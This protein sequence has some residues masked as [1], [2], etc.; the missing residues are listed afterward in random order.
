MAAPASTS[1]RG[2]R[3]NRPPAPRRAGGGPGL[4]VGDPA[5][6]ATDAGPVIDEPARQALERH[7][8]RMAR[9]G[10]LLYGCPLPAGAEHGAFF[11]PRA[12]E[13]HSAGRLEREVFGPI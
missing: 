2:T 12:L 4:S 7:A 8:A 13:I 1:P 3:S 6:L 10:R 11:P 5:L 9:E